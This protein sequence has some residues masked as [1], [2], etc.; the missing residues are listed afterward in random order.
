MRPGN[1]FPFFVFFLI[2]FK[3]VWFDSKFIGN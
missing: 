3:S 2:R 1:P